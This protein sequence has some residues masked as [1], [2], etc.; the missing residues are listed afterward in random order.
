LWLGE[1]CIG[2]RKDY[3]GHHIFFGGMAGPLPHACIVGPP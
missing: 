1:L 3:V 2:L